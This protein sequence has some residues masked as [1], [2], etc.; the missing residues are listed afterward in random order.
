MA[1][2]KYVC[3]YIDAEDVMTGFGQLHAVSL[4]ANI[5]AGTGFNQRLGQSINIRRIHVSVFIQ[6]NPEVIRIE[7][8]PAT[9]YCRM[10][11]YKN[12][13][14][15]G[16]LPLPSDILMLADGQTPGVLSL[17]GPRN[18]RHTRRIS[19]LKDY[20]HSMTALTTGANENP[21]SGGIQ[22]QWNVYP[23][24]KITYNADGIGI[25]AIPNMDVGMFFGESHANCCELRV[26]YTVFFT[27]V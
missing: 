5:A 9:G 3:R 17:N 19:F 22:F 18:P 4:I 2:L 6:P 10:G 20:L 23:R 1:E 7:D 8:G 15:Q 25:A 12:R 13:S 11:I 27:D 24:C 16:S 21:T 26:V 14:A